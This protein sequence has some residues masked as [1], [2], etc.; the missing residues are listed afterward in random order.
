MSCSVPTRCHVRVFDVEPVAKS[1][2][3]RFARNR[4]EL[5]VHKYASVVA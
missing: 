3:R 4:L 2:R 1:G 5:Y